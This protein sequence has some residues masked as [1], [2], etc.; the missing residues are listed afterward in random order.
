MSFKANA[1]EV[2]WE[3]SSGENRLFSPFCKTLF[4]IAP[5]TALKYQLPIMVM[6]M[7]TEGTK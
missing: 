7:G 4:R 2:N 6:A 3:M 5:D 1:D